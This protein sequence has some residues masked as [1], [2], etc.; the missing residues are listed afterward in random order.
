MRQT[1]TDDEARFYH[2]N[3]YLKLPGALDP[4]ELARAQDATQAILDAA[5]PGTPDYYFRDGVLARVEYVV[6]KHPALRALLAHPFLLRAAQT[7]IGPD[8]FP[9]WDAMVVKMPGHGIAVPWHRDAATQCVGDKPIFNVDFYLDEAT[10]ENCVWALPGTHRWSRERADAFC[11]EFRRD[12]LTLDEYRRLPGAVPL[13]LQPGDVLFHDILLLHGS[14]TSHAASL[15]RVVYY[16]F[17]TA[18]VEQEKGPHTP[19]YIPLK[20]AVLRG[21]LKARASGYALPGETPFVYAPPAPFDTD[22][23]D[24]PPTY[25]YVHADYWRSSR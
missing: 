21:C 6:D 14:P 22:T 19:A 4:A 16:E 20:Q 25:R 8:L 11:Q 5:V 12:D 9:T 24:D 1:I 23:G 15:R 3:G 7:L 13:L 18:A 10:E 17:R 2:E